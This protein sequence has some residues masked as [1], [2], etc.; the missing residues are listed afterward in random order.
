MPNQFSL[1]GCRAVITGSSSGLGA[2]FARQLAPVAEAFLLTARRGELLE[3]LK[4]ELLAAKPG[5]VVE[6][7]PCDI[8]TAEGRETLVAAIDRTSFKP[9]LLINNAGHGDYGPFLSADP[10]R[11]E[12]QIDLN[13]TALVLLTQKIVPRLTKSAA[14]PAAILN[15]SSL[16]SMIA[17]PDNAVYA[18]TKAFVTSFSEAMRIEFA[19]EHILV[20]ATCPGPTATEFC[21]VA[22]RSPGEDTD[23][24]YDGALRLPPQEVVRESIAALAGGKVTVFPGWGVAIAGWLFRSMPRWFV[25]R[26]LRRRFDRSHASQQ[27]AHPV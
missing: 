15:V 25:R 27:T 9:N 22:R 14:R 13:V 26:L 4:A 19:A 10:A 6:C 8:A 3:A 21:H 5:L 2:E 11:I 20:T 24:S 17:L 12:S 7:C 23:R 16:A 1:N 18:A